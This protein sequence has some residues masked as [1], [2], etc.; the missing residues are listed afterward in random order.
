[1]RDQV[2][3]KFNRIAEVTHLLER[4]VLAADSPGIRMAAG[5]VLELLLKK[6]L[7]GRVLSAKVKQPMIFS[8]SATVLSSDLEKVL[9]CKERRSFILPRCPVPDDESHRFSQLALTLAVETT[10]DQAC[11]M[12]L[13]QRPL[14]IEIWDDRDDMLE[15]GFNFLLV[16]RNLS[17]LESDS[18]WHF[19]DFS[20]LNLA[21]LD[22]R[23]ALLLSE[24]LTIMGFDNPYELK[25]DSARKFSA[26]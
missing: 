25:K 17:S 26:A 15:V 5:L 14:S 18:K 4:L 22:Q 21:Q 1:M 6:G 10:G 19:L 9:V 13:D 12:T 8:V 7:M 23:E 11:E 16:S 20:E 3:A 24:M 2:D